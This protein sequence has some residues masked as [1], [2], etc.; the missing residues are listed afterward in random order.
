VELDNTQDGANHVHTV[1]RD[2]QADFGD[3]V[4][5]AHHRHAHRERR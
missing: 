5:A 4:L 3:D 1:V 2:P